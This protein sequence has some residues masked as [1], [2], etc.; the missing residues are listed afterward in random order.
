M[1]LQ[2]DT[3]ALVF[4]KQYLSIKYNKTL[5][6]YLVEIEN[7]NNIDKSAKTEEKQREINR[8]ERKDKK[9]NHKE[10]YIKIFKETNNSLYSLSDDYLNKNDDYESSREVKKDLIVLKEKKNEEKKLPNSNFYTNMLFKFV[11]LWLKII[12]QHFKRHKSIYFIIAFLIAIYRRK[13][14]V[15]IF[16]FLS[17]FLGR[18]IIV[19]KN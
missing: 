5:Y 1:A 11:Y 7:K 15:F 13:D 3:E 17:N 19:Q 18:M 4:I 14:V 2:R 6:K 8:E 12:I 16:K 9:I 10:E